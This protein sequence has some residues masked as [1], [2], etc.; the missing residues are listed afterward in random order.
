ME[1]L[2]YEI[3]CYDDEYEESY[4][5]SSYD[6]EHECIFDEDNFL[7]GDDNKNT[8]HNDDDED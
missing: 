3:K 4:Y 8:Y 2:V 6:D 1:D 5:N 7:W